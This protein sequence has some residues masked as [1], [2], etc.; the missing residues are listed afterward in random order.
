M[1]KIKLEVEVGGTEF[2]KILSLEMHG[3]H[4]TIELICKSIAERFDLNLQDPAIRYGLFATL[5][6]FL[7]D[8]VLVP[9]IEPTDNSSECPASCQ[10]YFMLTYQ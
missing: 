10:F 5:R 2:A 9:N 3:Y 8:G 4:G 7:T 1:T 6:C